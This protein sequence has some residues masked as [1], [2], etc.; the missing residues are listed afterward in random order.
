MKRL[1]ARNFED[2]LQVSNCIAYNEARLT[3][4]LYQC[5]IPV[6]EDL[7]PAPHNEIVMTLLYRLAEWHALAKLRMHTESTLTSMETATEVLSRELCRFCTT[8]CTAFSTVEL[9]KEAM[10]RGRKQSRQRAKAAVPEESEPPA[11]ALPSAK[12]PK[13]KK[14][15]NLSTYKI[16]ALRDYVRTIRMFGTTDSYSSQ[17]VSNLP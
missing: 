8:I 7:L 1:A 3:T 4:M 9:P 15:L 11:P 16:H 17:T 12:A 13:R 6:F 5:A 14:R 2:I 10:A